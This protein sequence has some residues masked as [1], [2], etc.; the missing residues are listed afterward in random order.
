MPRANNTPLQRKE[1]QPMKFRLII[2]AV[3]L[4]V[5]ALDF[6]ALLS[7]NSLEKLYVESIASRNSAIGKDL[8]RNIEKYLRFGKPIEKFI[9][10]EKLL[11]ETKENV[12]SRI[13][14]DIAV[15]EMAPQISASISSPEGLM[16]YSPDETLVGTTLPE[17]F[18]QDYGSMRSSESTYLKIWEDILQYCL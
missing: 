9:G 17:H 8:Q 6:N 3:M 5:L 7:L 15:E 11:G 12:L 1:K 16:L 4:L 14:S 2:G 13:T 10:M 18:R